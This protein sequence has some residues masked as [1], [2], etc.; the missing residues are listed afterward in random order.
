MTMHR[1]LI[2][3]VRHIGAITVWL[4]VTAAQAQTLAL[5]DNLIGLNS[6]QGRAMLIESSAREAYWP[7]SLQFVTQK[8]PSYCGVASIVMVLNALG[9]HAPP[10]AGAEGY[11]AYTQDNLFN[12]A[13]E[14]ILAREV[15]ARQ[16]MTL[17]QL[18]RLFESFGVHAEVH[19][20]NDSSAEQFRARAAAAVATPGVH[21]V[22]NY[23]RAAIG[24][25]SGGHISPLAAYESDTDR[26]LVMDVSRY[27][28]PPVWA[29]TADLFE[30][31][32]SVDAG[33]AGKRRGFVVVRERS[34]E[35]K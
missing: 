9:R 18:G 23:L 21:V 27:K 16:G 31:M 7:L 25:Q 34:A 4:W 8:D 29:S 26:F 30:A 13:T 32:N 6:P 15:L 22:V 14:A 3:H 5:P 19:H 11:T 20:A 17:D 12:A 28:Y 2:R 24:Q 33:N 10:L 1:R 35:P